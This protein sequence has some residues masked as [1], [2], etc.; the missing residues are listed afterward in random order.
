MKGE[1]KARKI[2]IDSLEDHILTSISKFKT[3]KEMYD[4]IVGMFEFKI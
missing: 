1:I 3:S 4:K 2:I